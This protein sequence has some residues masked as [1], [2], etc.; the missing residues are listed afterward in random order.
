[1]ERIDEDGVWEV[2]ENAGSVSQCLIEPS[3]KYIDEHP[4]E[5]KTPS[6]TERIIALEEATLAIM[7]VLASV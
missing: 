4:A 3:Q 6:E 5:P 1:M 2:T 7:E